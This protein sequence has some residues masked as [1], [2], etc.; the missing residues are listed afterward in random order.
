[1]VCASHALDIG[2]RQNGRPTLGRSN[3]TNFTIVEIPAA[4]RI[5]LDGA[6]SWMSYRR[7]A[8]N[9]KITTCL[10]HALRRALAE[11]LTVLDVTTSLPVG[12]V[13]AMRDRFL[14]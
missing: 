8:A 9:D 14:P 10:K 2:G 11:T 4:P 12:Q 5:V 6:M 7:D 13:L 3:R 1:M